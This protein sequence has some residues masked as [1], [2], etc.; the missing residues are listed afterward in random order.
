MCEKYNLITCAL[1]I[2][3]GFKKLFTVNRIYFGKLVLK[4]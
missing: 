4:K 1:Q 2:D 3:A